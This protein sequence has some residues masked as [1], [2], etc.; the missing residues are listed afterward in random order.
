MRKVT[1]DA[2]YFA[3]G[4][5]APVTRVNL[6]FCMGFLVFR[7]Q[8]IGVYKYIYMYVCIWVCVYGQT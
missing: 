2:C 6:L 8:V 7:L 1:G 3:P 5:T 4:V